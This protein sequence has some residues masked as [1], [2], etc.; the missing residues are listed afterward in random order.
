MRTRVLILSAVILLSLF[1]IA[2]GRRSGEKTHRLG[3][4][5]F[6]RL[7]ETKWD[8]WISTADGRDQRRLL[9]LNEL[10]GRKIEDVKTSV[11]PNGD[12]L[13]VILCTRVPQ[14]EGEIV[15]TP[16]D[17]WLTSTTTP[18][19]LMLS[20]N[21]VSAAWSPDG[22]HLLIKGPDDEE[23]HAT[24]ELM[25]LTTRARRVVAAGVLLG[26]TFAPGGGRFAVSVAPSLD[27]LP[28]VF[29]GNV[30]GGPLRLLSGSTGGISPVW[31]PQRIAIDVLRAIKTSGWPTHELWT[32]SSSGKDWRR[33]AFVRPA[34]GGF[35]WRPVAWSADGRRLLAERWAEFD[36]VPYAL[37][38]G[39]SQARPLG[40]SDFV[41]SALSKNGR[42]VLVQLDGLDWQP[43]GRIEILP[44]DGG[45]GAVVARKAGAPSWNR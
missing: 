42:L 38:L 24:L 2:C 3:L 20:R 1:A 14:Q 10:T 32:V 6:V 8:L 4:L 33:I 17:L 27:S 18:H 21:V 22:R 12:R 29:V 23:E 16:C 31:G 30:R 36:S 25:N 28:H 44:F 43:P 9:R 11:A 35:S 45:S 13:A 40:Q 7:D 39:R 15:N 37:D 5:A 41:S 34:R 19:A 26:Y